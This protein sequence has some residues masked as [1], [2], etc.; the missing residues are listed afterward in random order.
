MDARGLLVA[1]FTETSRNIK[2]DPKTHNLPASALYVD[3]RNAMTMDYV[4]SLTG[5]KAFHDTNDLAE[6]VRKAID[7]SSVTYTLGYYVPNSEWDNT[8]HKIK[9]AVNRSG[10][11]VRTK[12]GY[13]AQDKPMPTGAQLE[14]V[15]KK[16][17]WSPLDSTRVAI[18]AR[19]EPSPAL[20]NASRFSFAIDPAGVE[21]RQEDGK[22][23]AQ[24]DVLFVQQRK[25]GERIAELKKTLTIAVTTGTLPGT[26]GEWSDPDRGPENTPGHG[27]RENNRLGSFVWSHRFRYCSGRGR[28]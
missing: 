19:I 20:P 16:A 11:N 7:D 8:Y 15:L 28:R 26:P 6:A 13:L 1:P 18:T 21:F 17:V 24:V 27:R 5:G 22:Y 25:G 4:A 9:V 2:P 14:D 10:M 3:N 23:R 12:K